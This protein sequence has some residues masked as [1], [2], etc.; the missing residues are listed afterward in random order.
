MIHG[1]S[2]TRI[3]RSAWRSV[4]RNRRSRSHAFAQHVIA[5]FAGICE[6]GHAPAVDAVFGHAL[7]GKSLEPVRIAGGL[8]AEQAVAADFLGR[9]AI[10]D[11]V[12]LMP[13]AEFTC[14]AVPQKLE[15]LD[16]LLGLVAIGAAKIS[17][18]IGPDLGVL[19]VAGVRVEIDEARRDGL[20][21]Q[22]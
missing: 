20:L 17:L 8:G 9:A 22:V 2:S 1:W 13:A 12:E 14:H 7:L 21:D 15:K 18:E 6:I 16:P 4:R 3:A 19:E 10:V 11:L 5:E